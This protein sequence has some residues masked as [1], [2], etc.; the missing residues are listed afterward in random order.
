M[1][2]GQQVFSVPKTSRRLKPFVDHVM[3]FSILDN[4]V[5]FRNYQVS[6][7]GLGSWDSR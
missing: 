5:W 4:K 6:V 7:G 3:V 1:G 2:C